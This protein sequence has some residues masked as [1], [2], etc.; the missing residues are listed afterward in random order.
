MHSVI[1]GFWHPVSS[2]CNAEEFRDPAS[3]IKKVVANVIGGGLESL[4]RDTPG[5]FCRRSRQNGLGPLT[6]LIE[7]AAV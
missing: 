4:A 5:E 3:S 7:P 6:F 1:P 2:C